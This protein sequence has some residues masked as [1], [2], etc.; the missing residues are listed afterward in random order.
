MKKFSLILLLFSTLC[1]GKE[2]IPEKLI[3]SANQILDNPLDYPAYRIELIL[4]THLMR[5]PKDL[6]EDFYNLNEFQYSNDLIK[7]IESP[8]LL[9]NQKSIEQG[10]VEN[11]QVI[12][13]II[14][15]PTDSPK[16]NII[17]E[18]TEKANNNLL[19]YGY[20]EL[21][22]SKDLLELSKRLNKNKDYEVLF[23]GSWFQPIFNESLASPV[24]IQSD[25]KE[26]ALHGELLLYKERF[27]HL[28]KYIEWDEKKIIKT[29]NEEY[30]W[31]S[32]KSY[33]KNQWR[34]GDGQTAFNNYV[35]YIDDSTNEQIVEKWHQYYKP[36]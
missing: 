14:H 25:N 21:V 2:S 16:I 12:K 20:F 28:F 29:L 33:G 23:N 6:E 1:L 15:L 3:L 18:E 10:L 13:N 27:L 36:E 5:E 26:I 31:E 8:S 11:K 4:F 17:D 32:D 35:Y 30:E 22:D 7:L 19:P 34:M 24:Y 9:V